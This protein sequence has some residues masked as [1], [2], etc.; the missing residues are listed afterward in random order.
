[1]ACVGG[2]N[3]VAKCCGRLRDGVPEANL[4]YKFLP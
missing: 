2:L 1:M 4:K 3:V